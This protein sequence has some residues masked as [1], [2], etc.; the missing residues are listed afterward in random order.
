MQHQSYNETWEEFIDLYE[1]IG[2]GDQLRAEVCN[3]FTA[4]V[5]ITADY[6]R[7]SHNNRGI[8]FPRPIFFN[9]GG[10]A[11]VMAHP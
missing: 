10:I 5:D 6:V 9:S 11:T 4:L 7:C 1:D 8:E 2:H 3:F